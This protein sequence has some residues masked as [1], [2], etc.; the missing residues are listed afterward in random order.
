MTGQWVDIT[1]CDGGSPKLLTVWAKSP[2]YADN[3]YDPTLYP[4]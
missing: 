3:G 2:A 1:I 4:T